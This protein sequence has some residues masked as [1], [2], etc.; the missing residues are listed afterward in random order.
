MAKGDDIQERLIRFAARVIHLCNALP[1]DPAGKHVAGQLLRSGTSATPNHAE[2]R[3]AESP[4]DF[5]HK[6]KIAVKE[7]NETEVWLRIVVAS[8]MQSESKVKD[9]LDECNQLQRILSTSIK[10]ARTASAP[11][12]R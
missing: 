6:L 11:V 8:D 7:L 4:A 3:G 5:V 2:A 1:R 12:N 10:T 9:L